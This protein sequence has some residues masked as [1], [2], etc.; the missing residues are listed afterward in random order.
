MILV[1]FIL[2][3]QDTPL[4]DNF[5]RQGSKGNFLLLEEVKEPFTQ[6]N[7]HMDAKS[8]FFCIRLS[9]SR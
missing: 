5:A 8:S 9:H 3:F 4:K 2:C 7:A 6:R 1:L